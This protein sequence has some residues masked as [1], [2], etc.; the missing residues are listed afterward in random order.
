MQVLWWAVSG[1]FFWGLGLVLSMG[2]VRGHVHD[3]IRPSPPEKAALLYAVW[4]KIPWFAKGNGSL[5]SAPAAT[6]EH[7][8]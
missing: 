6:T 7:A 1:K 5:G 8:V 2:W 4:L 3:S